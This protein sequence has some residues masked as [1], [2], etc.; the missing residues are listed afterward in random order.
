MFNP[1]P[2]IAAAVLLLPFVAA[3]LIAHLA[4]PPGDDAT[5]VVSV[6]SATPAMMGMVR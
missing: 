4:P 2:L 1:R 5:Q 3:L 6:A